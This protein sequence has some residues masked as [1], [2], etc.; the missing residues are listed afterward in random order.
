[1]AIPPA[2]PTVP[3]RKQRRPRAK[4]GREARRR[5]ARSSFSVAT[6]NILDERQ[7]EFYSAARAL[8]T[9]NV[10]ISVLQETNILDPTFATKRWA[11]YEIKSVAAGSAS[12]GGMTL[13]A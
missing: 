5:R 7:E 11:G 12:C 3:R 10:D 2:M 6:Y 4:N 1:M 9:A 13:L 8:R